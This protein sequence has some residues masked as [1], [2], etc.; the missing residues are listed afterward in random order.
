MSN[1][2]ADEQDYYYPHTGQER[3]DVLDNVTHVRVHPSIRVIKAWAF[4]EC[5][6]LLT[7]ILNDGL[8]EIGVQ[9]FDEYTSL[10]Q[11]QSPPSSGRLRIRHSG[12]TCG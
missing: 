2:A 7:V 3:E 12:V 4:S 9:A 5:W 1:N 6:Q 11:S 8:K 10:V